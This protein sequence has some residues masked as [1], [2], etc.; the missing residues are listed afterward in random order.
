MQITLG[1]FISAE[2]LA[3]LRS[4]SRLLKR[5]LMLLLDKTKT[6]FF[7]GTNRKI[8]VFSIF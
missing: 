1:L 8:H 4:F 6:R 5:G 3:S 7:A 2:L